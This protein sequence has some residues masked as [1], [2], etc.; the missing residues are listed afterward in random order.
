MSQNLVKIGTRGS[1]LALWQANLIMALLKEKNPGTQFEPVIIKTSGDA[2]RITALEKIG[3]T[4]LFTKKIEQEL[5]DKSIDIAVHSAKDLPSVMTEGLVIGA[6]PDRAPCED[7]WLSREGKKLPFISAGS[8]VGSGSPRRRAQL[9]HMRPDLLVEDIRGNVETRIR[10][11]REGL[12]DALLMAR[13]GLERLGLQDVITEILEPDRFVPAPGQG[14]LVVQ[15]REDDS[16]CKELTGAINRPGAHRMLAIERMLL[17]RLEAGCSTPVGGWAR[18]EEGQI[19]FTAVVLDNDG[20][21]RLYVTRKINFK[22]A[23]ETLVDAVV[24][25]L[26]SEGAGEMI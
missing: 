16:F 2:D 9:L 25:Q 26:L 19:C 23:D 11:M 17:A 1:R 8:T 24:E 3:G 15:V 14:S 18:V 4:G 12:Y 10:K 5:L 20:V 6:V 13:A 22:Q 7:V 21:R